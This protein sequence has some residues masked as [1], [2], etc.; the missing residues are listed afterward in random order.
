MRGEGVG[1]CDLIGARRRT[2]GGGRAGSLREH[3]RGRLLRRLQ[4]AA[5]PWSDDELAAAAVVIA[6][7]PDDETLGCGATIA[8][9]TA[10][11][12]PLSIVCLTDGGASHAHL[13]PA[14]KLR[15]MRRQEARDAA[16]V[17]GVS[18]ENLTLLGLPDGHLH[19]HHDQAV[20][21]VA[22]ILAERRPQQV[23][24]P[25]SGD[26]TADHVA[27]WGIA[28]EAVRL[29]GLSATAFE[30]P[31]WFWHRWPVS[32]SRGSG[33]RAVTRNLKDA[34]LWRRAAA[35][36]T[37]VADVAPALAAK[38]RAL[39][40]HRSQMTRLINDPTWATLG[41]VADGEFLECFFVG[42]EP[43]ATWRTS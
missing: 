17:L 34:W 5:R 7:H 4:L 2:V 36:W 39:Q 31:V 29:S 20:Q 25:F 18:A 41:D 40:Q 26:T 19:Q 23:F 24:L 3:L 9:K 14:A 35:R 16:S 33:W 8:L 21:R 27:A 1:H 13:M 30:Y 38:R 11:G 43:F 32:R 12:A 28:A 37:R 42:F 6:P 15:D 10:A 22:R